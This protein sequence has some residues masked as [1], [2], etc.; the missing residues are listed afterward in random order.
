MKRVYIYLLRLASGHQEIKVHNELG[1][2]L[3]Y[4]YMTVGNQNLVKDTTYVLY[5]VGRVTLNV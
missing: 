4:V 5:G 2:L 1:W 3:L